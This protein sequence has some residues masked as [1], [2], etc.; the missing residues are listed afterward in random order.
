M[1]CSVL[2]MHVCYDSDVDLTI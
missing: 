2:N 1:E